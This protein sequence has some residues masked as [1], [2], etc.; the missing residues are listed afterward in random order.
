MAVS[1]KVIAFVAVALVAT[2]AFAA[3][4]HNSSRSNLSYVI[5][6][7]GKPTEVSQSYKFSWS[8]DSGKTRLSQKEKQALLEAVF[9][10][11]R[12]DVLR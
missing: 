10:Q 3:E 11:I 5:P 2:A 12:K 7:G 4:D 6:V 8:I 9:K 1:Q